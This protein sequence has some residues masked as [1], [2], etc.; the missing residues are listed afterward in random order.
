[1]NFLEKFLEGNGWLLYMLYCLTLWLLIFFNSEY[2]ATEELYNEYRQKQIEE[3]YTDQYNEIATEFEEDL[4][5]FEDEEESYEVTDSLFDLLFIVIQSSTQFFIISVFIYVALTFNQRTENVSFKTIFKSVIVAEF[6]FFLPRIVKLI[7]FSILD[8]YSY[9]DLIDFSSLSLYSLLKGVNYPTWLNH[10]LKLFNIY[11]VLYLILL[12]SC[13]HILS[14]IK[15]R[16]LYRHVT[17]AYA[18]FLFIWVCLRIYL[19]TIF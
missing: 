15:I 13:V 8:E 4:D 6:V 9:K 3:N 16:H 7:W 17:L 5:G 12:V 2:I 11:E 14:Q 18:T 10:S 1:M 19:G